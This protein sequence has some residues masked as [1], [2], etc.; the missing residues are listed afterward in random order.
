M[1][2]LILAGDTDNNLGDCAIVTAICEKAWE[3][4]P[5]AT[6]FILSSD[7]GGMT[8]K[9]GLTSIRKGFWGV[10]SLL[11]TARSADHILCAGG[12]LFQDDDSL[13]KMPYWA[14]RLITIRAVGGEILS[15]SIGAGPL[16]KL[17][18]KLFARLALSQLSTIVVRDKKAQSV[19]S[20]LTSKR[21]DVVPDPAFLLK[22]A[23]SERALGILSAANIPSDGRPLIGVT[24]RRWFHK[25]SGIVPYKYL[26]MLGI[27][28]NRG[29]HQM[30]ILCS[31][32]AGI[33]DALIEKHNAH[34]V[35]LPTYNISHE[36]DN[37]VCDAITNMM[38]SDAYSSLELS[39]PRDYKAVTSKTSLMICGRMHPAILAASMKVPVVGL[40]YNQKFDGLFELLNQESRCFPLS[41]LLQDSVCERVL[42]LCSDSLLHRQDNAPDT[43]ALEALADRHMTSL[44]GAL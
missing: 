36:A 12:G 41:A 23:A 27:R 24:A 10:H 18:S 17:V 30:S 20:P 7:P 3:I 13:L 11:K 40:A 33:L 26:A 37:K 2:I 1:N 16:N 35:F 31:N 22:P 4:H 38:R 19:L 6:F 32:L 39:D 8:T 21:V 14:A 44:L 28:K 34:I 9:L 42:K 25:N 43:A 29:A 15:V 5:N